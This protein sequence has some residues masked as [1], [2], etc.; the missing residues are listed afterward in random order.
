MQGVQRG[1]CC[2]SAA[3]RVE[4]P[5]GKATVDQYLLR[6][7]SD[8]AQV[9][10]GPR[11]F[12][13]YEQIC[14]VH[15]IPALGSIVLAKLRPL[16]S[17]AAYRTILGKVSGQTALH[18]HR[19]LRQSLGWAVR[20]QLLARNPTDAV[21][22]PRPERREMRALTPP[23]I[24]TLLDAA[25]PTDL[26]AVVFVALGTGLRLGELLA[27]RWRDF[28][29]GQGT[30]QVVR[31]LQYLTG[32]GLTFAPTKTYR[33]DR[34]IMLSEETIAVLGDLRKC[35]VE[36]RLALGPGYDSVADL[37]FSDVTGK[38]LPPYKVSHRFRDLAKSAG[39]TPLRF[40][41]MRHSHATLLLR[42]GAYLKVVSQ[43]LGHA[44]VAITLDIYAHVQP[45]IE[46]ETAN[47]I[48]GFL[49]GAAK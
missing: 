11:T 2:A 23:E 8:Y 35:Q 38:P 24:Q 44:G 12:E 16:Q 25:R 5:P 14:R 33:S 9:N 30:L 29:A 19:V 7:L 46:A 36:N 18:C 31:S 32:K 28:N 42:A 47:L 43:R 22:P 26:Y 1:R 10:V 49:V 21:E 34:T 3:L 45:D 20:W 17:Q 13:R 4:A 48:D 6:W 39:L 15:L 37:I 41:D 40:H 27:I